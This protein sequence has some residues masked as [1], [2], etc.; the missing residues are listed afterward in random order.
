[1]TAGCFVLIGV[2]PQV[3][4]LPAFYTHLPQSDRGATASIEQGYA[5][6]VRK[7]AVG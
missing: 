1:M 3:A 4:V 5:R 6:R 2:P 7:V